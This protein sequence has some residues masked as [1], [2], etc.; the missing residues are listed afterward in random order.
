MTASEK[1][2]QDLSNDALLT[3]DRFGE[4]AFEPDGSVGDLLERHVLARRLGDV[5]V[6]LSH[7]KQGVYYVRWGLQRDGSGL[8]QPRCG[9]R[10]RRVRHGIRTRPCIDTPSSEE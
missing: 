3:D 6:P 2:D 4:L 8:I 7:E 1:R 9:V 10:P 5:Q